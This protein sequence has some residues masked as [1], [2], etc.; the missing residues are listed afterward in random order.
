M[1]VYDV[2][3]QVFDIQTLL[4]LYCS[5]CRKQFIANCVFNK[6]LPRTVTESIP[7]NSDSSIKDKASI[8]YLN[9]LLSMR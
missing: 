3:R 9:P 4:C 1:Y 2:E 5:V 7:L 8:T 6:F